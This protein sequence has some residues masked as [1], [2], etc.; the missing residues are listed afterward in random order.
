M[1]QQSMFTSGISN[2]SALLEATS[3]IVRCVGIA[4]VVMYVLVSGDVSTGASAT[5]SLAL[6]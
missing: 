5:L 4:A 2:F 6:A 3:L 1:N